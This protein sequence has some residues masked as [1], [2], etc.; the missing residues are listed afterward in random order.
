MTERWISTKKYYCKYCNT[1]FPDTKVARQQHDASDRHK[2]AMQRNLSRIQ[3]QDQINRVSGLDSAPTAPRPT[4]ATGLIMRN[5]T[6]NMAAYGYGDRDD[7]AAFIAQGKKMKFDDLPTNE[8]PLPKSA[9]EA[10]VGKWE[11]TQVISKVQDEEENKD[12]VK[13]EES[14]DS[15]T[16]STTHTTGKESGKRERLQTPDKEDLIRFRVEEKAFP[17]DIKDEEETKVPSVGFKKRK[18]GAKSSRISMA[19]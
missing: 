16:A 3:R 1:W 15:E 4:A 9:R 7:M 8:V 5:K 18:V 19:L 17:A 6:T 11:V 13:K 14:P 2:N 12:R 10:N